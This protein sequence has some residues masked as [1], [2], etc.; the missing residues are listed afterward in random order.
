MNNLKKQETLLLHGQRGKYRILRAIGQG[1]FGK[2]FLAVDESQPDQP[3]CV[4]KQFFPHSLSNSQEEAAELFRSEA[5]RLKQL[6]NHPQ[7]PELLEYFEQDGQQYIVQEF[8][9]GLNLEEELAIKGSLNESQV[10]ELLKDILPVLEFIHAHHVIHRDIKPA[11][12]IR[13]RANGQLVL[14][15]FGASKYSTETIMKKTGTLIGSP[16]YTAP[17]QVMG[18]ATFASDLYSLGVSCLHLLTHMQPFELMDHGT[19]EWVW[20]DYLSNPVSLSLGYVLDRLLERGTR[21][22]YQSATAVLQDLAVTPSLQT[23]VSDDV[24]YGA[25]ASTVEIQ[26]S[27][28]RLSMIV[29]ATVATIVGVVA[30]VAK[31]DV[32][33]LFSP[34]N[35][36]PIAHTQ[37]PNHPLKAPVP[38]PTSEPQPVQIE[39]VVEDSFSLVLPLSII[40]GVSVVLLGL[41]MAFRNYHKGDDIAPAF[42]IFIIG[43]F[44]L[45]AGLIIL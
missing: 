28:L 11:N 38:K 17:E 31:P 41:L 22:R 24:D 25:I 36:S 44:I 40:T 33:N 3:K 35:Q 21:S 13:R 4:V 45:L 14:V 2:T 42:P 20:R 5:E 43:F 15:D 27:R 9:D 16:A 10:L 23:S 6:G 18:K 8:I 39:K 37:Q 1:G 7:I 34:T 29:T 30:I 26:L 12:L 32:S 19:G